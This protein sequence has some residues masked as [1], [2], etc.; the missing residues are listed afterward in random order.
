M[1][2]YFNSEP[3][4]NSTR[5]DSTCN[6]RCR[7]SADN[8]MYSK[9]NYLAGMV[10]IL[11]TG[12]F[13]EW[14]NLSPALLDNFLIIWLYAKTNK[15]YS[16]QNPKT[17]IF[18]IGLIIGISIIFYHPSALLILIAIFALMVVRP[19]V[20]TEWFI[21]LMGVICPFYFLFS[22]LYLTDKFSSFHLYIPNWQLNLPDTLIT[23]WFFVTIILIIVVLLIGLF[24]YQNESLRLLIQVRKNWGVLLVMLLIMLPIPFI[25]KDAGLDSLLLWIVP[26]SPFIAKGFL[27]PKRNVLPNIMFWSLIVLALIKNWNLV[28]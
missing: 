19:F 22:W 11:L 18:N 1:W 5:Q 20:I 25:N 8:R 23:P 21:L 7:R 15:L 2:Q 3:D 14:N 27:A 17:L 4:Y 28:Q 9:P 12:L 24:Y 10:Y 13:V 26:A 16:T 6:K